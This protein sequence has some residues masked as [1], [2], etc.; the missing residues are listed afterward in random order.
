MQAVDRCLPPSFAKA[1]T[2]QECCQIYGSYTRNLATLHLQLYSGAIDLMNFA[3]T[4]PTMTFGGTSF[5]TT[6]PA[7]LIGGSG[8]HKRCAAECH[9]RRSSGEIHQID[10]PRIELKMEIA[11]F[12]YNCRIFDS[13]PVWFELWQRMVAGNDRRLALQQS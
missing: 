8:G 2:I 7:A 12:R 5:V 9:C 11:K 10:S 4:P 3:G 6:A 13:T 1:Q